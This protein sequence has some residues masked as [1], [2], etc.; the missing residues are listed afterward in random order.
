[1]QPLSC[2][3][4]AFALGSVI[5]KRQKKTR[6]NTNKL[7]IGLKYQRTSF[8]LTVIRGDV[9]FCL[10]FLSLLSDEDKA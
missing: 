7:Q 5:S 8:I 10:N 1:M 3:S 6:Y 2:F 4:S 9:K